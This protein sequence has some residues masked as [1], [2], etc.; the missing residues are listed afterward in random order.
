MLTLAIDCAMRQINLGASDGEKLL[1]ELS[2]DV[3]IRQSELLPSAVENFL[4]LTGN[5]VRGVGHIVVTVGPGYYTGIRVGLS[6]AAALAEGL[7]VAVSGVSTLRA[8]ALP[9]IE[10]IAAVGA[11]AAVAPVIPAG[12]GSIY[13]ALY[14]SSGEV[15]FAPAHIKTD[16]FMGYLKSSD[17][18]NDIVL[19]GNDL[20]GEL[21]SAFICLCP[22]GV[23][24]GALAAARDEPPC[25]PASIRAVYLRGPY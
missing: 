12:R 4:S 25:D 2:A 8:M 5:S 3:G 14:D 18:K 11:A 21:A 9:Q 22:S 17:F 19:A 6:Y 20:P 16:D 13:A 24:R 10:S 1:G 23:P 7:G 15:L